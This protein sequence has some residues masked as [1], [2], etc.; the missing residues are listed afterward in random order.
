MASFD[1]QIEDKGGKN[2]IRISNPSVQLFVIQEKRSRVENTR[3]TKRF[4]KKKE[5]VK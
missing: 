1:I 5:A 4:T 3:R 2:S